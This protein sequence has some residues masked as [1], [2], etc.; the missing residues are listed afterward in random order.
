MTYYDPHS[1]GPQAQPGKHFYQRAILKKFDF[2][3]DTEAASNFPS[4]VDISYSWGKPNFRYTQ[5][6]HRSGAILAEIDDEGNFLVLANRIYASRAA[7]MREKEIQKE[8]RSSE[9]ATLERDRVVGAATRKGAPAQTGAYTP[10]GIAEPTPI[11]SPTVKPAF[12]SSPVARPVL[13]SVNSAVPPAA[14]SADVGSPSTQQVK[15]VPGGL[16]SGLATPGLM[17]PGLGTPGAVITP[18]LTTPAHASATVNPPFPIPV[19]EAIKDDLE[20]FCLDVPALE[21]FYK[22][23]LERECSHPLRA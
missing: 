17:T 22:D 16:S 23:L 20:A 3:L 14:G 11:S 21:A 12:F 18:G 5:F 6:I 10:Y 9:Q 13:V 2:V 19:P 15:P 1:F 4:N 7:G 8:M